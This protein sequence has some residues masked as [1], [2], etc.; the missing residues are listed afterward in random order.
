MYYEQFLRQRMTSIA[1]SADLNAMTIGALTVEEE[2]GGPKEESDEEKEFK[3]RQ[4]VFAKDS[5]AHYLHSMRWIHGK[6][7]DSEDKEK[8][9]IT[10]EEGQE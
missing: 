1:P 6:S 9:L 5:F 10:I 8:I 3:E 7:M 4:L 2:K